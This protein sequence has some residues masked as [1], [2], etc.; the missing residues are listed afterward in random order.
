MSGATASSPHPF[1]C[2]ELLDSIRQRRLSLKC[3]QT[4]PALRSGNRILQWASGLASRSSLGDGVNR[5]AAPSPVCPRLRAESDLPGGPLSESRSGQNP[6]KVRTPESFASPSPRAWGHWGRWMGQWDGSCNPRVRQEKLQ[7]QPRAGPLPTEVGGGKGLF[8]QRREGAEVR[9]QSLPH[10]F[11]F[12]GPRLH[13]RPEGVRPLRNPGES[14]YSPAVEPAPGWS[15]CCF[16]QPSTSLSL[17]GK[18]LL[19]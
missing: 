16:W 12:S 9:F 14:S 7:W 5:R 3:K 2:W 13:S 1:T 8:V 18:R 10:L 4:F 15:G 11:A 17:P 19:A 6:E